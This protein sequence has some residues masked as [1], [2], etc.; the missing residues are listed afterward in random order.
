MQLFEAAENFIHLINENG[1]FI[2]VGWCKRGQITDKSL[3]DARN[4]NGGNGLNKN[5]QEGTHVDS[6]DISYHIVQVLGSNQDFLDL[7]TVLGI[8]LED[9]QCDV[10]D[11]NSV[12]CHA[13]DVANDAFYLILFIR[14]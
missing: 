5:N 11:V 3:I 8:D 10:R 2:V 9:L 7:T 4:E 14:V 6:G 1:G 12:Q 13:C